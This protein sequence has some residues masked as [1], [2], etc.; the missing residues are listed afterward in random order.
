MFCIR[1]LL[2]L[3]IIRLVL[4]CL[5]FEVLLVSCLRVYVVSYTGHLKF[6]IKHV[7]ADDTAGV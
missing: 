6:Q 4:L 2:V 1:L 5:V 7:C 3:I